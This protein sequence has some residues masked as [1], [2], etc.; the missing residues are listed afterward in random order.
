MGSSQEKEERLSLKFTILAASIIS[1]FNLKHFNTETKVEIGKVYHNLQENVLF[2]VDCF[3]ASHL[4]RLNQLFDC[5]KLVGS[6]FAH[7]NP[8]YNETIA[9]SAYLLKLGA[10]T[11]TMLKSYLSKFT[12]DLMP[13]LFIPK[14]QIAYYQ[15]DLQFMLQLFKESVDALNNSTFKYFDAVLSQKHLRHDEKCQI[16]FKEIEK[17]ITN[18]YLKFFCYRMRTT[19]SNDAAIK[20]EFANAIQNYITG[21]I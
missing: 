4:N 1:D 3:E 17:Y 20:V 15:A 6:C 21:K 16:I 18:F 12:G 8:N 9:D 14:E 13:L 5:Y 10:E 7:P 11:A 2:S 19:F